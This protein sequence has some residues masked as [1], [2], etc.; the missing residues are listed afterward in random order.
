MQLLFWAQKLYIDGRLASLQPFRHGKVTTK[1][2]DDYYMT[3]DICVVCSVIPE[4]FLHGVDE[5]DSLSA[6]VKLPR[7]Y[8]INGGHLE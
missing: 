3:S 8:S 4:V 5:S 7:I 6:I 2:N 1:G